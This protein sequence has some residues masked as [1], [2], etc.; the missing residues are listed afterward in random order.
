MPLRDLLAIG[1]SAGGI[2]AL[3]RLAR[4]FPKD[5]PASVLVVIHLSAHFGSSLDE[6]LTHE[7]RLPA[8]F[9]KDGM[10][11]EHGRIY[12]APLGSHLLA[13]GDA[14]RLDHG[15]RENNARPS[16]DPMFRSVALSRASRSVGAV[17][18][19][20]LGDGASG[21]HTL[22][23]RGGITVVQDPQDAAYSDMPEAVLKEFKPHHVVSLAAMPT[24]FGELIA[25]PVAVPAADKRT[26]MTQPLQRAAPA[27][28]YHRT[29]ASWSKELGEFEREAQV[30]RDS[31]R[32]IDE[33]AARR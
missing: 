25:Q 32:R 16:I 24:L 5:F 1:T 19:G 28:N 8:V 23:D 4:E 22:H 15:P 17:L 9:A 7:G 26:A 29:A 18:T 12:I 27:N 2:D 33:I 14:L 3:C 21:L 20:S 31:I 30:L 13:A 10:P 11:L 6:I